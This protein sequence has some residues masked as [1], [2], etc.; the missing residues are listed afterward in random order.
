M[1]DTALSTDKQ[2]V[3][4]ELFE[5]VKEL[6]AEEI[7]RMIMLYE[8]FEQGNIWDENQAS[9]FEET[10]TDAMKEETELIMAENILSDNRV[11]NEQMIYLL[12]KY[13]EIVKEW[14]RYQK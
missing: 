4:E 13:T 11:Q 7:S 10:I 14:W 6:D 3:M 8:L 1:E 12:S 5:K 9:Y 2:E